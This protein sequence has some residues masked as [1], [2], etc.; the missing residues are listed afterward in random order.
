M[1]GDEI[2]VRKPDDVIIV[3]VVAEVLVTDILVSAVRGPAQPAHESAE[4]LVVTIAGEDHVVTA[5]VNQVS[6][7]D[8]RMCQQNGRNRIDQQ[9]G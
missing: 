4:N 5:L 2:V 3:D 1:C 7:D 6:G 9:T 8:H